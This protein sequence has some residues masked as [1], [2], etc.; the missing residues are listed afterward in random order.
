MGEMRNRGKVR[1]NGRGRR[2]A[3]T[4]WW[5]LAGDPATATRG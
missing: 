1:E 3:V 2:P 4:R 5:R